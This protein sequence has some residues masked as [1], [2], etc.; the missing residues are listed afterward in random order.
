MSKKNELTYENLV[1]KYKMPVIKSNALVKTRTVKGLIGNENV[2]KSLEL[3]LNIE[4]IGYNIYIV[5][6]LFEHDEKLLKEFIENVTKDKKVPD[7]WC[8][9]YNFED[10]NTPIALNFKAKEGGIFKDDVQ[11]IV[12][13]IR[14]TL[15]KQFNSIEFELQ[16]K[17][18]EDKYE[19]K[20]TELIEEIESDASENEFKT[21]ITDKDIYFIPIINEEKLSEDMFDN[22]TKDQQKEVLKKSEILQERATTILKKIKMYQE[23]EDKEIK[24]LKS[25][26]AKVIVD[27]IMKDII[28]KYKVSEKTYK[29]LLSI[30][31]YMLQHPSVFK[32][33]EDLLSMIPQVYAGSKGD[34]TDKFTVNLFLDNSHLESAP[35]VIGYNL[36]VS[37]LIGKIE[38]DTDLGTSKKDI[39]KIKPGLLH[40]ANGGYL[41]LNIEELLYN[42][43][44]WH[45]LKQVLK[46]N[47]INYNLCKDRSGLLIGSSLSPEE[48]EV[49]LKIVL[50]GDEYY[51]NL[52]KNYD[53]SFSSLF[54]TKYIVE[55]EVKLNENVITQ[56][57]SEVERFTKI[58][59]IKPLED[60]AKLYLLRSYSREVMNRNKI[61]TNL[62]TAYQ[63]LI[64]ANKIAG[65]NNENIIT[66][67][68]LE[69]AINIKENRVN[70]YERRLDEFIDEEHILIDVESKRIG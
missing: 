11:K 29:Y 62:E 18:I 10:E 32:E 65:S 38:C 31:Q 57:L 25:N 4:E 63:T 7:D 68:L 41:I 37:Q 66:K 22:L 24:Q 60:D 64:E 30:K 48:I 34:E 8:Y 26:I 13:E 58:K 54:K 1:Y 23:T 42:P 40:E 56:F 50:V 36:T 35:V 33:E 69:E 61:S 70:Y 3:G 5:S 14:S 52:L 6:E 12:D 39:L 17:I 49:N 9:V 53:N 27:N 43:R 45:I 2:L 55:S 28:E 19:K 16:K 67:K 46:T 21:E 20:A 47:K 59:N 44:A 51:C 15:I